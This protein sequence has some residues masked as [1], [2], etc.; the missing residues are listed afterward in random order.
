MIY[1]FFGLK[2]RNVGRNN[3]RFTQHM[4]R[5]KNSCQV[6]TKVVGV[7]VDSAAIPSLEPP[8]FWV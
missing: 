4:N 7:R 5:R 3:K 2:P 6:A 8:D 1:L